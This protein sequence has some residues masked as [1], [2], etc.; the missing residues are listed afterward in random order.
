MGIT[1]TQAAER[2]GVTKQALIKAAKK[3]RLSAEKNEKG[4]WEVEPSELFRLYK[5]KQPVEGNQN[6]KVEDNTQLEINGLKREIEILREQLQR[7]ETD[8]ADLSKKMD[9]Q[10]ATFRMLTDTG[11]KKGGFWSRMFG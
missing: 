6:V 4:E 11:A 2:V 8:K 9:D 10:L 1:L 5:P 7:A 3:G